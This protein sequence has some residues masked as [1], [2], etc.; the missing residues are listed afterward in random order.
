MKKKKILLLFLLMLISLASSAQKMSSIEKAKQYYDNKDYTNAL[1][2]YKKAAKDGYDN[3]LN[4]IG[5]IYLR[6]YGVPIDYEKAFE[7]YTKAANLGITAA[8]TNLGLMY[9]DGLGVTQ[10]Y[11]K[12]LELFQKSGSAY[13]M[14]EIGKMFENGQ[15]LPRDY[16]KALEWYEKADKKGNNEAFENK[17]ALEK[18]LESGVSDLAG[19]TYI[20][21]LYVNC[22][23]YNINTS[24]KT[25]TVGYNGG[26]NKSALSGDIVILS[27]IDCA[28]VTCSVNTIEDNAF[29]SRDK[30]T[31]VTIPNSIKTIGKQAFERCYALADF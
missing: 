14:N 25:A 2:W 12:A 26:R 15:G 17:R 3:A 24:T 8:I 10:N 22:I 30:I 13:A 23:Y 7:Y 20:G 11:N 27:T 28:G 4:Q 9:K 29:N 21:S 18:K 19:G 5:T 1:K 31:S 16:N 6:G